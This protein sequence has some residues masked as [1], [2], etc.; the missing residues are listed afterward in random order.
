[1][2][3]KPPPIIPDQ[4]AQYY[5]PAEPAQVTR[6]PTGSPVRKFAAPVQIWV[7][8]LTGFTSMSESTSGGAHRAQFVTR[9]ITRYRPD[10]LPNGRLEVAGK[11]FELTGISPAPNTARRSYLHLHALAAK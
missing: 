9:F 4:V 11:K 8:E 6:G 1:M 10:F 2:P 5:P 3:T 7:G